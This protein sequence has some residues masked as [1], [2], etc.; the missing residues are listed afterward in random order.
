MM[1]LNL[2][3]PST[4]GED[5]GLD[6][7]IDEPDTRRSYGARQAALWFLQAHG[8]AKLEERIGEMLRSY[9]PPMELA[10]PGVAELLEGSRLKGRT[11]LAIVDLPRTRRGSA[12]IADICG[13]AEPDEFF[14][15]HIDG[16]TN[17]YVPYDSLPRLR[18]A[19]DVEA[20]TSGPFAEI[21]LAW[22]RGNGD[23]ERY[24]SSLILDLLEQAGLQVVSEHWTSAIASVLV[25]QHQVFLAVGVLDGLPSRLAP[26]VPDEFRST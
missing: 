15:F 26:L 22:G 9:D 2:D 14:R 7:L 23:V 17:V 10:H 25:P 8:W 12:A 1:N 18:E 4:I 6:L 16:D 24:A 13:A 20:S 19:I 5:L 11:G 3:R 21:T